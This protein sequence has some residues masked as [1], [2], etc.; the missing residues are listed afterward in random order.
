MNRATLGRPLEVE[1]LWKRLITA[2]D[3]AAVSLVRTSFSTVI[4][5]FHDYA[6]AIFDR[7]GRLLAQ[8]THST[9]GLLGIL[10]FTIPNFL[11]HP[12]F[13][14]AQPG[15][16]FVTNDP[17]LASGHLIDI[18]VARPVFLDT[19]LVGYVL[20]VVHHLNVG[21]RVATLESRSVYEEG[22]KI[23]ILKLYRSGEPEEAVFEFIRANVL[24][25]EKVIGDL[26]A[27]VAASH[28]AA[29]RLTGVMQE[30]G[31]EDLVPLGDEII[32]R[33]AASMR[34]AIRE[35]PPGSYSA[36]LT[37][38]G[39]AGYEEPL[40]IRLV[41]TIGDGAITLDYEGTSGQIPRAVNVTLNMT[42]S[43]SIYP[44][45]CLLDPTVPNNDGCLAPIEVRAP[46]GSVLNAKFPAATWGRTMLAHML[47]EL[48][49]RCFAQAL[50]ERVLAGSGATPLW[51][52]NFRGRYRDGRT[53]YAVVTFNG[54]LGARHGRDG[55]S[56]VCYPANCANVPVE[57]IEAESPLRFD[58]KEFEPGSAG[59]GKFRGGL[60]QRIALRVSEEAE[61]D[62]PVIASVRGGRFG[63]EIYGLAGGSSVPEPVAYLNGRP[64]DIGRQLEM[65]P[66]DLLQLSTPGGGGYG[67][68]HLRD[69][70][71]VAAD[72][73]AGLLSEHDAWRLHG[74]AATGAEGS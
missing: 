15:D 69:P 65:K 14:A 64:V 12:G 22:L 26:R 28:A 63:A 47:P 57:V 70:Q 71:Q 4:R 31:L 37:L 55:I 59:A 42:R 27:Q 66:G 11:R 46:E 38:Q 74:A 48:I 36:E 61:L 53:F 1:L 68:P 8:S 34:R 44:L 23:P 21:G 62:G 25:P 60:G 54:G 52:G 6:C 32:E 51:Y 17:W 5:D 40:T 7:N 73:R 33:S 39:I 49:M 2:V 18:T 35:L 24:E 67:D 3:E 16:V 43:Y 19:L 10:P 45:K 13:A 56:C 9:P 29:G 41:A 50:P 30:S 72:V 58:C 20:V